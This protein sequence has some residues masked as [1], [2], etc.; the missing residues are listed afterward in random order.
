MVVIGVGAIGSFLL[1]HL[2]RSRRV[3]RLTIVDRDRYDATN[4]AGQDIEARHVGEPKAVAQARRVRHAVP[5]LQ[6]TALVAAVEDVPLGALQG[7]LIAACL[8]SRAARMTVNQA[9]WRLGVPWVDA[10]IDAGGLLARVRVYVPAPAAACL[11]CGWDR[12]DYDA[13]EQTYPCAA[14]ATAAPTAAPSALGALAAAIQAIECDKLLA[15]DM[16]GALVGREVLLDAR[17]N[18]LLVTAYPRNPACRMPD[19]DGW[20]ISPLG[21]RHT[22][23]TVGDALA[24][25]GALRGAAGGLSFGIAGQR[26]VT[27][28]RCRAC[29][30]VRPCF[31]LDRRV[32][33]SPPRCRRCGQPVHPTGMDVDDMLPADGVPID[34]RDRPLAALGVRAR[35]VVTLRTPELDAHFLVD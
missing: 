11:E 13:L 31:K 12:R 19:H 18:T 8:D 16:S 15:G 2:A 27:T 6:V 20:R 28:L 22:D 26:F 4:I 7:S 10:G 9:A 35:D 14:G 25:G 21:A 32:R 1:R 5:H 23:T 29:G 30:V 3:S 34:V 17:F 33:S 24:V